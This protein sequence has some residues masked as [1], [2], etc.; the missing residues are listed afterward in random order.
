M[1]IKKNLYLFFLIF[2]FFFLIFIIKIEILAQQQYKVNSIII[3]GNKTITNLEIEDYLNIKKDAIVPIDRLINLEEK[4]L[5][6]G[7]FSFVSVNLNQISESSNNENKEDEAKSD[8]TN[9]SNNDSKNNDIIE[10]V[11]QIEVSENLPVKS[12]KLENSNIYL[13][14]FKSKM[15]LKENKAFNP[16]FLEKDLQTLSLY[17]FVSRVSSSILEDESF[18]SIEI[19]IK[20][21]NQISSE[22]SL[23]S[24]LFA[25]FNY[26]FGKSY[27]PFYLSLFSFYPFESENYSPSFGASTG[28]SFFKNFY[29]NISFISI[30]N[31]ADEEI[32]SNTFYLG[33][34]LKNSAIKTDRFSLFFNPLSFSISYSLNKREFD[35][36]SLSFD[37][38]LKFKKFL[39]FFLKSNLSYYFQDGYFLYGK[40]P[41][42]G[43]QITL[44]YN[45]EYNQFFYPFVFNSFVFRS[46]P[47]QI[48]ENGRFVFSSSIDLLLK[49]FSTQ[50]LYFGII[51]SFDFLFINK[52]L[53]LTYQCFGIGVIF[54][55]SIK[56]ILELPFTI[57]Y[58]WDQSIES[59]TF[60]F[61]ILSKRFS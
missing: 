22:I 40:V 32:F 52:G 18:V 17:P 28:V 33:F 49:F 44:I 24:F 48:V 20:L 4:L 39:S 21:K 25:D 1:K 23:S 5:G 38:Y 26:F 55:I 61:T 35:N 16:K 46:E 45:R 10:I 29:F 31:E 9:I 6:W 59:G 34:N 41:N 51:G 47:N 57:Q 3:L 43:Q 13:L 12:I 11:I 36:T 58:F 50:I 14:S 53:N 54:S 30:Y 7:Y 60:Y 27:L 2:L 19:F 56:N 8:T 42:N 15:R 37:S